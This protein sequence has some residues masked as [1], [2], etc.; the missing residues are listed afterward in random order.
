[1][2]LEG[3]HVDIGNNASMCGRRECISCTLVEHGMNKVVYVASA[4]EVYE[5]DLIVWPMYTLCSTV[6]ENMRDTF[7]IPRYAQ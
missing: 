7:W 6:A 4:N 2:S 1:M 5:Q 3:G